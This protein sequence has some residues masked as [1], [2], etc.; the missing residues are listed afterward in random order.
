[1]QQRREELNGGRLKREREETESGREREGG[2]L[3]L[4]SLLTLNKWQAIST[5]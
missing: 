1:M 3:L 2:T 4:R 5:S